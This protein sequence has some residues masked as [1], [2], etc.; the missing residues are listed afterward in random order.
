M[1]RIVL[2]GVA[3]FLLA[4]LVLLPARWANGLLPAGV[5]CTSWRGSIWR[6]QCLGLTIAQQPRPAIIDTLQWTLRPA[7]LLRL[8][9]NADVALTWSQG[10][11]TGKLELRRGG[12]ILLHDVSARA[13]LD[14]ELMGALPR[15]WRGRLEAAQV[16]LAMQHRSLQMLSGEVTV[17][18]LADSAGTALGSYRLTFPVATQAPFTGHLQDAGGPFE[19]IAQLSVAQDRS[20]QLDGTVAARSAEAHAFD[21]QLEILGPADASGRRRLSAAGSFN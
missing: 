5:T 19:V 1:K 21:S 2:L 4:M 13:L 7:A 15:G 18:D 12:H 10:D 16:E 9:V 6:G 3:A 14:R 11:V 20:W 17:N 8:R